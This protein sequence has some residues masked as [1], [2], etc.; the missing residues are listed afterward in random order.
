MTRKAI[1]WLFVTYLML[2][3]TSGVSGEE[4]P[5]PH[6]DSVVGELRYTDAKANETLLDIA[7]TFDLGHDQIIAA[8]PSVNRWIPASSEKVLVPSLY[9]LPDAEREGIV[10]NL[11]ELRLYYFH[12]PRG[13]VFTY[14]ISTGKM[15]WKTPLGKT[16]IVKKERDPAWYPPRSIRE[17]R[18][19]E[20]IFLPGFIPGGD[21]NNPLGSLALRLARPGYLIHGTDE[22]HAFGIGLRVTHG[23]IRMYP[24]DIMELF[25][26][27]DV[28]TPVNI[29]DHA[30]KVGRRGD[31]VYL[32]VHRAL[33]PEERPRD[34]LRLGD[35][36]AEINERLDGAARIDYAAVMG[37]Y[38]AGDGIPRPVGEYI[39]LADISEWDKWQEFHD[40]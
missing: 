11:A 36:A 19:A 38:D 1:N 7:R 3:A 18:E 6:E 32:S 33:D 16:R 9:I 8:N 5:L 23:C 39:S 2:A 35:V 15:D 40:G 12:P 10:L 30:V 24:E 22:A 13:S 20:G 37:V 34:E 25:S 27:V 21:E 28:G 29:I 17:E 31:L 14:P 4:Y 26:L